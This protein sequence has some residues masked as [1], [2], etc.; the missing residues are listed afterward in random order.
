RLD[1][2]QRAGGRVPRLAAGDDPLDRDRVRLAGGSDGPPPARP[3]AA[4]RP[5]R[6]PGRLVR[7][8]PARALRRRPLGDPC[9]G[10]AHAPPCPREGLSRAPP[11]RADA[12][13][14]SYARRSAT[15]TSRRKCAWQESNLRPRAPEAR[16]LSPELPARAGQS[17]VSFRAFLLSS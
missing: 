3:Q 11:R 15:R 17:S 6:L 16:A 1:R 9:G 14:P 7:A 10:T 4:E 2:R 8:L 5:S 12:R 13:R